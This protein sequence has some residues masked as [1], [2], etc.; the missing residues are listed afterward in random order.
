MNYIVWT[1]RN[2]WRRKHDWFAPA[3]DVVP[4]RVGV[5]I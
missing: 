5:P 2:Q 1:N 3:G 4:T